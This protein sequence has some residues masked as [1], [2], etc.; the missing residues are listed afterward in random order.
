MELNFHFHIG[1]TA[2]EQQ[3]AANNASGLEQ[4]L[5]ALPG[6]FASQNLFKEDKQANLADAPTQPEEVP[7]TQCKFNIGDIVTD[8]SNSFTVA[9]IIFTKY[10]NEYSIENNTGDLF[11][12]NASNFELATQA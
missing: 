10:G 3:E 5:N 4:L 2:T 9:E 6:L 1:T 7:T 8:G 11:R 12:V